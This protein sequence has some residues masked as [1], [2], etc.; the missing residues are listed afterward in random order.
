M[1]L[2]FLTTRGLGAGLL[3]VID[4]V[5]T[6]MLIDGRLNRPQC[7]EDYIKALTHTILNNSDAAAGSGKFRIVGSPFAFAQS[8][9]KICSGVS[10][11]TFR[12]DQKADD[13]R[14]LWISGSLNFI[15]AHELGHHV[16]GHTSRNPS[17]YPESRARESAADKFA[18]KSMARAGSNPALSMPYGQ[19][20]RRA[21]C[22]THEPHFKRR[23]M[24]NQAR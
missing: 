13:L 1:G 8:Q 20:T 18:F 24:I 11:A 22:L 19:K 23:F 4:W 10:L 6:A 3:A 12:A 15:L 7:A 17:S 14:E 5:S 16:V 2:R 9:P 21:H